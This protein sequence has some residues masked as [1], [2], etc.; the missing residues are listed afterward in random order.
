MLQNRGTRTITWDVSPE[1]FSGN[2]Q[3]PEQLRDI[4]MDTVRPGSIILLHPMHGRTHTQTAID[5]IIE[6]LTEQG[7]SFVTVDELTETR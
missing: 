2:Q 3:T 4:V 1:D 6:A 7:Y 5:L